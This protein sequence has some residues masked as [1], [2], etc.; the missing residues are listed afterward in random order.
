MR[1]HFV[2]FFSP[3]TFTA[4]TTVREIEAWDVGKALEMASGVEERYGATPYAFCF[5]T[6]AR[7]DKDFDSKE[8]KRSRMYYLPH[9]KV[10]TLK[11]IKARGSKDDRILISNMEGNGW[12][13]VITTTK[14]WK[15]YQPFKGGDVLLCQEANVVKGD[16][17]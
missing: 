14:G 16:N 2:K 6:R 13:R 12:D 5:I 11:E 9:C 7:A 3:G 15:W 10:E 4:E 1:K 17:G 8:V